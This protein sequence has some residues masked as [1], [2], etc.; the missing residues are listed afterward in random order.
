[1]R[2]VAFS[3]PKYSGKDTAAKA[4]LGHGDNIRLNLFR[5]ASMAE[6]VKNICRDTFGYT[7]ELLE[8]PLLKETKTETWPYLEPRWPMMDIANWMRDKYGSDIW[9]RRWERVTME[10][11]P[12]WACHVMTDLRFP[13]EL[14]M[15]QRLNALIIYI[16]RTEAEDALATKQAAGNA[17]ALNPSE[18]HYALMRENAHVTIYNDSTIEALHKQVLKEVDNVYGD[19]N[20]WDAEKSALEKMRTGEYN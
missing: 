12:Y 7:D 2:V 18:A 16:Y 14:E 11:D 4:L 8:D 6:G 1:M 9:A 13:E 20:H 10:A 3:G 19:W 17:M 15:L 5:R